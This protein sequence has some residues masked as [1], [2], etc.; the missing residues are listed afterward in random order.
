ML[1]GA[2]EIENQPERFDPAT[3]A[4]KLID[5]DHRARYCWAAPAASGRKVLDAGCGLGYGLKILLA[6]GAS[7]VVGVDLDADTVAE[8]RRRLNG[9]AGSVE[10]ADI[11]DLQFDQGSFDLIV[12]FETIEHIEDPEGALAEFRRVLRPEGLLLLSS[13]DPDVY[14]PG[15][16]HHV[17]EYKP[18]EL[19][20]LV[21][22]HF[23]EAESY[24]QAAWLAS[25]IAPAAGQG[26]SQNGSAPGVQVSP[27]SGAAPA[28]AVYTVIAA[29]DQPLPNLGRLLALAAPFEV[30]WWSEQVAA[31]RENAEQASAKAK[32]VVEAAKED[33][34][35]TITA[36][37]ERTRRQ[38]AEAQA[39]LERAEA[40]RIAVEQEAQAR[41][42]QLE[43]ESQHLLAQG[44]ERE[45]LADAR[46][47]EVSKSLVDANQELAQIPLLKHRLAEL[48]EEHA[49][50]WRRFNTV[51]GSRSWR[52]TEPLRKFRAYFRVRD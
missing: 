18:E 45:R 43:K 5:A 28:E 35:E 17:H 42:E 34:R 46:L 1:S 39:G 48:H 23:G 26:S 52:M 20:E 37:E 41:I 3:E 44:Q 24:S 8:A 27:V 36:I 13:P 31:A 19:V 12:C 40:S 15:N 32:E 16:E 21:S 4:G 14:P 7:E 11:R 25:D 10:Q 33:A 50:L 47:R 9:D 6:A 30:R 51:E 2:Q 22:R 38:L 29:S 49:D